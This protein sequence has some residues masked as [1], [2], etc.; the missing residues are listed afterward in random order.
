MIKVLINKSYNFGEIAEWLIINLPKNNITQ[1]RWHFVDEILPAEA[2][3]DDT[4]FISKQN[5]YIVF[6][7][8]IDATLFLL[9]WS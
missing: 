7:E 2:K 8:E 1:D 6:N 4:L 5:T 9:R 3:N